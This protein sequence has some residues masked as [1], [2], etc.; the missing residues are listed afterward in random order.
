M[1]IIYTTLSSRSLFHYSTLSNVLIPS[2][3]SFILFFS[4]DWFFFTFSYPLLKFSLSSNPVNIFMTIW[5]LDQVGC[6]TPFCLVL[7]LRF[8]V[9][10]SFWTYSFLLILFDSVSTYKV[11]QLCLLVSKV[12]YRRLPMGP[13]RVIPESPEPGASPVWAVCTL[14]GLMHNCCRHTGWW[15]WCPWSGGLICSLFSVLLCWIGL[16]FTF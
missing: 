9:V 16:F 6:L 4:S 11:S 12:F 15:S 1:W 8:C 3:F 2:I 14:L 7:F 10:T 5:T 13:R